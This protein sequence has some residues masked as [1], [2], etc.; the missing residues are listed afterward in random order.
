MNES[1]KIVSNPGPSK[2]SNYGEAWLAPFHCLGDGHKSYNFNTVRV[3]LNPLFD[4]D[5]VYQKHFSF[6][7][8]TDDLHNRLE[9]MKRH[10]AFMCD[11][12]ER[13]I[14]EAINLKEKSDGE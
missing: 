13:Q 4:F 1:T 7:C 2:T 11:S 9:E 5:I 14:A 6:D 3:I 8:H 10:F 12:L